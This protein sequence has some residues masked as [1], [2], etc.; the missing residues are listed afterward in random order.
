MSR[1]L[2][3]KEFGEAA[4]FLRK[5]DLELL[6]AQTVAFDGTWNTFSSDFNK[7]FTADTNFSVVFEILAI[8][9]TRRLLV[10]RNCTLGS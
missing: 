6:A 9:F 3:M 8:L 1:L 2:D 7:C 5:S 10:V 4:A